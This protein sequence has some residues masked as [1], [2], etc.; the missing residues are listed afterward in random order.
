M[1]DADLKVA[2]LLDVAV[3]VDGDDFVATFLLE[4]VVPEDIPGRDATG[5]EE[6][7]LF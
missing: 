4:S 7:V 3:P 2:G 6:V 5:T 1:N